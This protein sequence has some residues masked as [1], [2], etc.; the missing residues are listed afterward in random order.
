MYHL[1]GDVHQYRVLTHSHMAMGQN[2]VAPV[3]IPIPKN[4]WCTYKPKWDPK[5]VLTTTAILWM[6]EIHFAPL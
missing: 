5:T 2:A 3:N 6:D 4:G 1:S